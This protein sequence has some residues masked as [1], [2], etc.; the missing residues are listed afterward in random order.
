MFDDV[1]PASGGGCVAV[2]LA[3]AHARDGGVGLEL[4]AMATDDQIS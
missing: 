3:V 4:D 1:D 2:Q